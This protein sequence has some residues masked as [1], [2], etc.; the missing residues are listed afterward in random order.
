[1]VIAR[2]GAAEYIEERGSAAIGERLR[3]LAERATRDREG[4]EAER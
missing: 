1:V 4:A 2:P 3:E